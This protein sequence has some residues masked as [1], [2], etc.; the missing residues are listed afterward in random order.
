MPPVRPSALV[1]D[2]VQ[3]QPVPAWSIPARPLNLGPQVS[4][5]VPE[6]LPNRAPD[7]VDP[8]VPPDL[9]ANASR[10][11]DISNPDGGAYGGR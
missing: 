8:S 10:R 6:E 3:L 5:V 4:P 1:G 11:H 2:T 7:H 9:G